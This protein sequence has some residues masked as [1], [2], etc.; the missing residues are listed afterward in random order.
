[1][2]LVFSM[3]GLTVN[4]GKHMAEFPCLSFRMMD[5]Q[6]NEFKDIS[7]TWK[8]ELSDH[9]VNGLPFKLH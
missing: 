4:W 6:G 8:K 3:E 5:V 7:A 2:L 1:M 9:Y